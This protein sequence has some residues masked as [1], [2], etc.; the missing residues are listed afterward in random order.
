[1][2]MFILALLAGFVAIALDL[3]ATPPLYPHVFPVIA[4]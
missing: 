3:I 4:T 1:M 2:S